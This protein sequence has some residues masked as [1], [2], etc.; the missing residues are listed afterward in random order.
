[1]NCTKFLCLALL[2]GA[3][4][5]CGDKKPTDDKKPDSGKDPVQKPGDAKDDKKGDAKGGGHDHHGAGPNGGVIFDLG[6][7]HAEFTVNHD[8]KECYVLFIKGDDDKAPPLPV[9]ATELTLTT[10]PSKTKDGKDV[11]A[12]T[13]A[14]KPTDAK[15]GKASKFVGTDAGLGNVADFAGT[16]VG[17][18]DKKPAEGEFKE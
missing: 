15:D 6:K 4:A 10:K 12:M 2:L 5:G 17:E 7:Y 1:M 8:K 16:V 3:L 13:I 14:L 11:P 18:I 9:A